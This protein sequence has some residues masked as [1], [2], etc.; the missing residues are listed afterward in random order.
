MVKTKD[1]IFLKQWKKYYMDT[2]EKMYPN[3]KKKELDKFL[4]KIIKDNLV[5]P[6]AQIH[7]NYAHQRLNIDL[8]TVVDWYHEVKPIVGGFGVFYRNQNQVKNPSAVMLTNFLK[9]RKQFKN[10]LRDLPK[11]SY[12]Y[13]AFDRLQL[14]EKINANSLTY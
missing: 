7:N 9:L 13:M 10:R 2:L 8:L 5:N 4:E 11:G 12:D 3:A 1:H 14:T 6:E